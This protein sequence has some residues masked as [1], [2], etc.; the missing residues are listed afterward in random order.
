MLDETIIN[1]FLLIFKL[2]VYNARE[3]HRL[4]VVDLLTDIKEMKKTIPFIFQQWKQK[5]RYI[6][7]NGA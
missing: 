7:R 5:K 6:K 1:N 3:K 4:S 2:Y